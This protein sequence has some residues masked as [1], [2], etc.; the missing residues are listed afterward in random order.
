MR[1]KYSASSQTGVLEELAHKDNI[2]L[3]AVNPIMSR[4]LT[5]T[6]TS[7]ANLWDWANKLSGIYID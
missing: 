2:Q 5:V 3:D 4:R 6:G 7:S 1:A